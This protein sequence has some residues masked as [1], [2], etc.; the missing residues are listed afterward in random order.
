MNGLCQFL[1]SLHFLF[2]TTS[3]SRLSSLNSR[4]IKT[5]NLS[6]PAQVNCFSNMH[7]NN[8]SNKQPFED[9]TENGSSVNMCSIYLKNTYEWNN[10]VSGF[11]LFSCNFTKNLKPSISHF[12]YFD[13]RF[14]TSFSWKHLFC[15]RKT[16]DSF[17]KCYLNSFSS[18]LSFFLFFCR[19]SNLRLKVIN[20]ILC[21]FL[22]QIIKSCWHLF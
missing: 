6:M 7:M 3:D 19:S 15:A 13:L 1:L 22:F 21:K 5:A 18:F 4:S 8:D 2:K 17:F 16:L 14:R 12:Q 10:F 9:C 20:H 11:M